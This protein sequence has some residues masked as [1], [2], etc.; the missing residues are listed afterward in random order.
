MF[1]SV[2][3]RACGR[4]GQRKPAAEFAWR[5]KARGQR[6]NYCRTCRADYKRQHYSAHRE[7]YVANAAQRKRTTAMER[8][9]PRRDQQVRG[10]L[11]KLSSSPYRPARRIRARGGSST[12]EPRP[13]KAMMRVRFPSAAL[14]CVSGHAGRVSREMVDS[15]GLCEGLVVAGGVECELAD[16]L[17]L[18]VDDADLLVGDEE[19]DRAA[20]V[21]S[22]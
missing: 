6:D 2:E 18:E 5:R 7:R 17:A 15:L 8:A 19:L 14:C 10:R 22:S 20:F 12:V 4:C 3:L 11:C 21:G 1:V 16:E 13:S 9:S